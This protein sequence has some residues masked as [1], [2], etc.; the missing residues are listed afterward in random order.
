MRSLAPRPYI[1]DVQRPAPASERR[2]VRRLGPRASSERLHERAV[3][4]LQ[5]ALVFARHDGDERRFDVLTAGL[6]SFVSYEEERFRDILHE[7]GFFRRRID[8]AVAQVEGRD[9]VVHPAA[10][11]EP[12]LRRAR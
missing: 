10:G 8:L 7:A 6:A 1:I 11:K 2:S 12:V 3:D 4:Y 5:Q 9:L